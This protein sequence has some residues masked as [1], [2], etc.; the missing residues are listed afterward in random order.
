[1]ITEA[2]KRAIEKYKKNNY[3]FV[4]VRFPKGVIKELD[5]RAAAQGISR[6]QLILDALGVGASVGESR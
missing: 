4:K 5:E 2:Q 3:D 1:M 6:N